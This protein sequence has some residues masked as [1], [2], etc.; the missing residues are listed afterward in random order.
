MKK[1][2]YIILMAVL[3]TLAGCGEPVETDLSILKST[4]IDAVVETY[5]ELSTDEKNAVG[6]YSKFFSKNENWNEG[7]K[8][9][10]KQ[11]FYVRA[12]IMRRSLAILSSTYS[13]GS[14]GNTKICTQSELDEKVTK[15]LSYDNPRML[16]GKYQNRWKF[17]T[18][19][20]VM[21][22]TEKFDGHRLI[23][24]VQSDDKTIDEVLVGP[25][26]FRPRKIAISF[27][28]GYKV[29]GIDYDAEF[30]IE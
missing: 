23:T 1:F 16:Y 24:V 29:K 13:C 22:A 2:P 6:S 20:G 17:E 10:Q 19:R 12:K 4:I 9:D 8:F 21:P 14:I 30:L 28:Y 25:L 5:S 3:F 27:F 15:L 7:T 26:P 18:S 11:A